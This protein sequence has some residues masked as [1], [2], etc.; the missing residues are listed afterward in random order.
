MLVCFP[1]SP[2]FALFPLF[3]LGPGGHKQLPP[4]SDSEI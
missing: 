4:P 1:E 2:F 3:P